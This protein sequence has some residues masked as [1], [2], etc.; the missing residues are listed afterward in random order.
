MFSPP[1][2]CQVLQEMGTAGRISKCMLNIFFISPIQ[3]QLRTVEKCRFR[4]SGGF[5]KPKIF[6]YAPRQLMVALRL[7]SLPGTQPPIFFPFRR[8]CIE[9]V[10]TFDYAP[11]QMKCLLSSILY[12]QHRK[13]LH[14]VHQHNPSS[15][16]SL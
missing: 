8:A 3:I 11:H 14:F 2:I 4:P 12:V 10:L 5:V 13:I 15:T 1:N 6:L 9:P 7:D 16:N